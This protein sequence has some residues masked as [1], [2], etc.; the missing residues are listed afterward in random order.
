MAFN[1][2]SREHRNFI[3]TELSEYQTEGSL[4]KIKINY[5]SAIYTFQNFS[6]GNTNK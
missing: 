5:V 4:K 6:G 1:I 3:F 2:Y